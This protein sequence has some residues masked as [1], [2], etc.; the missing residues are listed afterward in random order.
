MNLDYY[1]PTIIG[2]DT[3]IELA[4]NMLSVTRKYLDD[5]NSRSDTWGYKNTYGKGI[6]D[7]A[8]VKP[9]VD[10]VREKSVEY[11]EN[12][13]YDSNKI[14]FKI[15]VFT[16]EMFEGDG[17]AVHAHANCLLSGVFYLQAPEGSSNIKFF[18]PRPY[19]NYRILPIKNSVQSNWDEVYYPAEKGLFLIWQS[20]L[21]H[22]V[23]TNHSKDGRITLVFNILSK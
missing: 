5:V 8:D 18:D 9:F 1:F 20:W 17:H 11:F 19:V 23:P 4:D 16:S 10:Y 21:Q 12:C 2:L 15:E 3:N 6:E 22:T 13:G 14:E 7:F